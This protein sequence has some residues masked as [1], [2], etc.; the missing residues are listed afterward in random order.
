MRSPR[1]DPKT[2]TDCPGRCA[3]CQID[4]PDWAKHVAARNKEYEKR[5]VIRESVSPLFGLAYERGVKY[6]RES[7]QLRT[8]KLRKDR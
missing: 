8:R 4:C 6:A 1:Y 5:K 3:K 7:I 2:N